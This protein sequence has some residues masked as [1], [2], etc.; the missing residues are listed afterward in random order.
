MTILKGDGRKSVSREKQTLRRLRPTANSREVGAGL[1]GLLCELDRLACALATGS[2][3]QRDVLQV[4]P[5]KSLARLRDDEDALLGLKVAGLAVRA[6]DDLA[7]TRQRSA[8][9]TRC[10]QDGLPAPGATQRSGHRRR[11]GPAGIPER[12]AREKCDVRVRRRPL[13]HGRPERS[14]PGRR[15]RRSS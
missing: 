15:H 11:P 3:E 9:H 4:G 2:D 13:R 5:V 6:V 8:S 7:R 14:V 1:L 12:G 10:R